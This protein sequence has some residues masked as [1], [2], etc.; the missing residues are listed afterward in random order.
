MI[1]LLLLSGLAVWGAVATI[2]V[3]RSDGFRRQ[4]TDARRLP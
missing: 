2:R 4:P 1:V 3:V